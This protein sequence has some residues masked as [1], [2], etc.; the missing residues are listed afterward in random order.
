[1]FPGV[2]PKLHEI[3][4]K[5][6]KRGGGGGWK[7]TVGT[8]MLER[9]EFWWEGS[10]SRSLTAQTG[11]AVCCL[12]EELQ[13]PSASAAIRHRSGGEYKTLTGTLFASTTYQ[14][15]SM[16]WTNW[17]FANRQRLLSYLS[18]VW[19]ISISILSLVI[20]RYIH[21][22]YTKFTYIHFPPFGI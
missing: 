18:H 16:N 4:E 22:H 5:E 15:L 20:P 11:K 2:I 1:M 9:S 14:W 13:S 21:S 17:R 3:N 10:V 6:K 19:A 7:S 12:L 8:L